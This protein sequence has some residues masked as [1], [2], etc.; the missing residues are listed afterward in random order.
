VTERDVD[1]CAEAV[2]FAL[3]GCFGNH[4]R[5]PETPAGTRARG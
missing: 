5:T 1:S 3:F 2:G 4:W